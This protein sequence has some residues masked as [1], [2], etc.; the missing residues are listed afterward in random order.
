MCSLL[1]LV[2]ATVGLIEA[3]PMIETPTFMS[4]MIIGGMDAI[5]GEFPWQLSQQRQGSTGTW[6]HSC[7]ASLLSGTRALSAAHCVDGAATNILRVIAGLHQRTVMTG[8]QTSDVTSYTMHADYNSADATFANDIAIITLATP[9]LANGGSIQF[10]RL[11]ANDVN[12]FGGDTCVIS[13]WG[14]TSSSNTLPDTL[15]KASIAV[16]A[17]PACRAQ[18]AGIAVTWEKHICVYD[19]ANLIGS[20]NGDSG[21]P[22]NCQAPTGTVVAGITSWG[23]SGPAG[24]CQQTRPSVYTRTSSY[25]DWIGAN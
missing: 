2:A 15:Q 5:A 24:N 19:E 10:A 8:T 22:L 7:G 3:R 17:P 13:G 4:G 23:V 9:I 25:L 1:L 6:S 12:N 20:C 21:G 11:P 18:F 14:R 16:L